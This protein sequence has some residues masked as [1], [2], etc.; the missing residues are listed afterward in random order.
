MGVLKSLL[1]LEGYNTG[2]TVAKKNYNE[3]C[4]PAHIV[5]SFLHRDLFGGGGNR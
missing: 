5:P 1:N 3:S 2:G 4:E